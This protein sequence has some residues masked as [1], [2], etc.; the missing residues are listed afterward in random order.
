MAG[1][2]N[3]NGVN[4]DRFPRP[5]RPRP[6]GADGGIVAGR[7]FRSGPVPCAPLGR[8]CLGDGVPRVSP[9]A[10]TVGPVGAGEVE[11]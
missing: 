6:K 5:Y 10:I 1:E 9:W 11:P 8:G 3:A 7:R 2:Y 4:G